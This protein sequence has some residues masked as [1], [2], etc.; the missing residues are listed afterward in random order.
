MNSSSPVAAFQTRAVLSSDAVTTRVPSGENA[1]VA[2]ASLCP[3]RTISWRP[4][5]ASQMRA[6]LSYEAVTSRRP[7][8]E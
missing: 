2:T 4:L 6:V 5:A 1:A 7:S 8:D 3:L